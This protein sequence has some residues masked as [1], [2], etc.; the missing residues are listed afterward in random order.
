VSSSGRT[1]GPQFNPQCWGKKKP[2][3][4]LTLSFPLEYSEVVLTMFFLLCLK[5]CSDITCPSLP[6]RLG[7]S[8][9]AW[10]SH[11]QHLSAA[12]CFQGYLGGYLRTDY[13]ALLVPT[14]PLVGS[15]GCEAAWPGGRAHV[16]GKVQSPLASFWIPQLSVK[17]GILS[18]LLWCGFSEMTQCLP[19]QWE[20]LL[21]KL[22]E[23]NI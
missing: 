22:L 16:L 21:L 19:Q 4:L 17:W 2:R 13:H 10:H 14:S 3:R 18:V 11:S 9:G 15:K 8:H 23:L 1:L 20:P 6:V 5:M 7:S 12:V